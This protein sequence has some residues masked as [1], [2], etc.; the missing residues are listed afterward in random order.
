MKIIKKINS[1]LLVFGLL[2]LIQ[3]YT[4]GLI[5]YFKRLTINNTI[6]WK[7]IFF[8]ATALFISLRF[9]NFH[10]QNNAKKSAKL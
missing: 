8:L 6:Y 9:F 7:D 10:N 5:P 3:N 1:F 4:I 2:F